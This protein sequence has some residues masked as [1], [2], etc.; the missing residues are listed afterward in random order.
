M[1]KTELGESDFGKGTKNPE[2]PKKSWHQ[3]LNE[4][5]YPEKK[6][7]SKKSEVTMEMTKQGKI[8]DNIKNKGR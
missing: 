7:K 3:Y 1:N 8:S 5:F 2:I 4:N 6:L